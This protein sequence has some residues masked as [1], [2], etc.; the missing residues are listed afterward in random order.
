MNNIL[1]EYQSQKELKILAP[2]KTKILIGVWTR[3]IILVILADMIV[4]IIL[5]GFDEEDYYSHAG[6]SLFN[7]WCVGRSFYLLMMQLHIMIYTITLFLLLLLFCG[8]T[9]FYD[10]DVVGKNE[11]FHT[12][13]ESVYNL[14]I[15]QTTSN[16]PDIMM[17]SYFHNQ[18]VA[19]Y[20]FM[21]NVLDTYFLMSSVL[22]VVYNNYN[23]HIVRTLRQIERTKEDAIDQAF[24][25]LVYHQNHL[26]EHDL[27][28][29]RSNTLE[30]KI[31]SNMSNV[32]D[33]SIVNIGI[34][35]ASVMSRDSDDEMHA[36]EQKQERKNTSEQ[37]GSNSTGNMSFSCKTAARATGNS[38]KP[39]GNVCS[40]VN[41]AKKT[42]CKRGVDVPALKGQRKDESLSVFSSDEKE[43]ENGRNN[44]SDRWSNDNINS[45]N[46][47][48]N[49]RKSKKDKKKSQCEVIYFSAFCE[50]MCRIRPDLRKPFKQEEKENAQTRNMHLATAGAR[51]R[52]YDNYDGN[53]RKQFR[54]ID[55]FIKMEIPKHVARILINEITIY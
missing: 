54:D 36:L 19:I 43:T 11:N 27:N 5:L 28:V 45:T 46:G 23:Q 18:Y 48:R 55:H 50:L 1:I 38:S 20:F 22:A 52:D 14:L 37:S 12:F 32:F 35:N 30:D 9:L 41:S 44:L 49:A 8:F 40:N 13:G 16:F 34:A 4:T 33:N 42:I 51:R 7:L 31:Q 25:A 26:T 6:L 47:S 53:T 10:S 2:N 21:Y 3:L 24:K 29:K 17:E 39:N 15:L